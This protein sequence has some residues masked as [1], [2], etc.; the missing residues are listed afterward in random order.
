MN[1]YSTLQRQSCYWCTQTK[2]AVCPSHSLFSAFPRIFLLKL[3]RIVVMF[4]TQLWLWVFFFFGRRQE[5]RCYLKYQALKELKYF[6]EDMERM[7]RLS[8]RD[9]REHDEDGLNWW[10][11]TETLSS[12]EMVRV[13]ELSLV[14]KAFFFSFPFFFPSFSTKQCITRNHWISCWKCRLF[15]LVARKIQI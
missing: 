2:R 3:C 11:G 4:E 10:G 8:V 15:K 12:N 7:R 6:R 9:K 14:Q 1:A 13:I 5:E